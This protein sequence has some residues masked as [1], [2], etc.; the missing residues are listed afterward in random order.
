MLTRLSIYLGALVVLLPVSTMQAASTFE[1]YNLPSSAGRAPVPGK[2]I[3]YRTDRFRISGG[4][5]LRTPTIAREE[6]LFAKHAFLAERRDQAIKLLR[7]ELDAGFRENRANMLLRLGQLYAEKYMELSYLENQVFSSQLKDF[8][9]KGSK[10]KPPRLQSARSKSYLKKALTLFYSLERKYP[11]HPKMDEILFFIGFVEMENGNGAKGAKYLSR[12]ISRYPRSRKFDEAVVYLGDYYFGRHKFTTAASKYSILL[13][14]KNA[15]WHPYARYKIAWCWLN[16]NKKRAA[17]NLMKKLVGQLEDSKDKAQ[18]NLRQQAIQDLVIFYGEVGAVKEAFAFYENATGKDDALKKVR[19]IADILRS[20]ALDVQAI[21]AYELLLREDPNHPEAP[22]IQLGIY[23]SLARMGKTSDSIKHLVRAIEK[24]GAASDFAKDYP[25]DKKQE[26][27]AILENLQS[28]GFKVA[29][30][31]HHAAQKGTNRIHFEYALALYNALQKSFP[32]HPERKKIAFYM[33]EVLYAQKKWEAA[34]DYYMA[35]SKIAPK[36]KLTDES[37]Y[38]ALLSLDNLTAKRNK[39]ERI[40]KDESVSEESIPDGERKFI[41][42]AELYIKE[43][44]KGKRIVEV[45]FRIAAIYYHYRHLDKALE[46]FVYISTKHP[47]HKSAVTS[48]HLVLDIYNLKKDYVN[49]DKYAQFFASQKGF[50]GKKFQGE[51]SQIRDEI[52]FKKIESLEKDSKWSSAGDSYYEVYSKNPKGSLAEK[53]LYNALVSYEKANDSEKFAKATSLFLKKYPRSPQAEKLNLKLAKSADEEYDF[54]TAQKAYQEFY[55]KYPKSPEATKALFNSAVYAE[56]LG[57][58]RTALKLYDL[59]TRRMRGNI[60]EDELTAIHQSEGNL[61]RKLNRWTELNRIYR[62]LV[63]GTRSVPE[64]VKYLS[65]LAQQY[66]KGRR[67]NDKKKV[68]KEILWFYDQTKGKGFEG[69]A[70]QYAAEAKFYSVDRT[71]KSYESVKL[72]FPPQDLVYLMKRKQSK[73]TA[74]AKLY[75]EVVS[76]GAPEWGVAALHEKSQSYDHYV[77]SYRSVSI[78]RSYNKAQKE[79]AEKSL[80]QIDAEV[81]V[82]LEKRA[83]EILNKCVES[84]K[85]YAVASSYAL[86]CFDE[87]PESKKS[88]SASGLV[89]RPRYWSTRPLGKEVAVQ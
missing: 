6:F 38:N 30:F 12:V 22:L 66:E 56:L 7:Q 27:A 39:I 47:K 10:G 9:Q 54:E 67:I 26:L 44:P 1:N 25:S 72:R 34:A 78:P 65:Q 69:L 33:G 42:V 11:K 84:A 79:E 23:E 40:K 52:Q 87:A 18:F 89:P 49:L 20:K 5:E 86:K 24:Y 58:E 41:E 14:R 13:R 76:V 3:N 61:N 63:A 32:N 48:A 46:G 85:E 51:M 55:E 68:L 59:Y 71:Q 28:E 4:T 8:E 17:L 77:K 73:L 43:Y 70:L 75:D 50:G 36:D 82:P 83:E 80:K 37:V 21:Q 35:A 62:R 16:T 74:L 60:S 31:H 15:A 19:L 88:P 64:K 81:V 57:N 45:R 29:T 2:K 53:S